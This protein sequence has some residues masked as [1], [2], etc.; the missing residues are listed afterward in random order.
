MT[1]IN[2][3]VLALFLYF[4]EDKSEYIPAFITSFFFLVGAILT[5]K[6]I[7]RFSKKEAL[8]TKQLEEEIMKKN[9]NKQHSIK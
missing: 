8:K 4:P 5:M 6:L 9:G 7:I 2:N 3:F 1:F